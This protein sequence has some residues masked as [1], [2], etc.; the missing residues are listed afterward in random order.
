MRSQ[1]VV[2]W[3]GSIFL[4]LDVPNVTN[5]IA[6]CWAIWGARNSLVVEGVRKDPTDVVRYALKTIE[7]VYEAGSAGRSAGQTVAG[8]VS[9]PV[10]WQA[11]A[12]GVAKVNVDAGFVGELGCGLG[13][14]IRSGE[15]TVL[16]AGVQQGEESWEVRVAEAQ[17]I[18][19]GLRL[20]ASS[21]LQEVI[22]ESDCLQV[23]QALRSKEAG[24]SEF[25]LVIKDILLICNNFC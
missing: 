20:A 6:I 22:V 9:A 13:A 15:G 18:L 12:M 8:G 25:H 24:S 1:N 3:W 14:V 16:A 2:D 4:E 10:R 17:A 21:G 7:E 11:L 19:W 5:V 23:I